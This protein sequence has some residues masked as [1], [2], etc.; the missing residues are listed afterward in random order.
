[1]REKRSR[2]GR[3]PVVPPDYTRGVASANRQGD[4]AHDA[5]PTRLLLEEV[6]G[7]LGLDS[8][9][10]VLETVFENGRVQ[11]A[12]VHSG[13]LA[14]R[15][16]EEPTDHL[17]QA[18]APLPARAR[19]ELGETSGPF[20]PGRRIREKGSQRFDAL[21]SEARGCEPRDAGAPRARLRRA[22]PARARPERARPRAPA[23][24]RVLADRRAPRGAGAEAEGGLAA[25]ARA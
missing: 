21:G 9:R 12:Y 15:E 11:K 18:L 16:L 7:R 24:V 19:E 3:R 20:P 2:R 25:E 8:G 4:E 23:L 22:A 13:A 10:W 14:G 1:M 5:G 6:A 17:A